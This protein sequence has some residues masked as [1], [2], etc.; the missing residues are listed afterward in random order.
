MP[1]PARRG[2]PGLPLAE[3]YDPHQAVVTKRDEERGVALCSVSAPTG[4]RP[5]R[6]STGSS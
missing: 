5:G 1:L 6:P 3:A 2:L 4:S